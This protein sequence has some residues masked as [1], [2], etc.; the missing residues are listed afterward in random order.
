MNTPDAHRVYED[1]TRHHPAVP[2]TQPSSS[3][4]G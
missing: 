1:A 4:G 3:E 2:G